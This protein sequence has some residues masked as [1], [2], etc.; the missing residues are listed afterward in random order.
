MQLCKRWLIVVFFFFCTLPIFIYICFD[1]L[2][3]ES[4][5]IVFQS[6]KSIIEMWRLF[7]IMDSSSLVDRGVQNC[8]SPHVTFLAWLSKDYCY[9]CSRKLCAVFS[10]H[11]ESCWLER[12]KFWRSDLDLPF[13]LKT[14]FTLRN[15]R[16]VWLWVQCFGFSRP[17]NFVVRFVHLCRR[18]NR[19]TKLINVSF[20]RTMASAA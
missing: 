8:A 17:V 19:T 2:H 6:Q 18:M 16:L 9:G 13:A 1:L 4:V 5:V 14:V 20:A 12:D 10:S 11:G 3:I 7:E 15:V